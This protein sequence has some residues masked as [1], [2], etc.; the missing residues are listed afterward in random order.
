MQL[1]TLVAKRL[2]LQLH[3]CEYT[4]TEALCCNTNGVLLF[5]CF[6]DMVA[7]CYSFAQ[8]NPSIWC[9]FTSGGHHVLTWKCY[10]FLSA[11]RASTFCNGPGWKG[12]WNKCLTVGER[13]WKKWKKA[14][15]Q[16]F[17]YFCNSQLKS[18]NKRQNFTEGPCITLCP[19]LVK[20][21][22]PFEI[23]CKV[24]VLKNLLF[25]NTPKVELGGG[26]NKP[27]MG[28]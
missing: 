21:V 15:S 3:P 11:A 13:I 7:G 25:R 26:A 2:M 18:L 22:G 12:T 20:Y 4:N 24:A 6:A 10:F 23:F 16:T 5:H 1:S 17:I 27:N 28:M 8:R 19:S 14:F 9:N